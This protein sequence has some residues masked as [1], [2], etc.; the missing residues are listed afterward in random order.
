MTLVETRE[1]TAGQLHAGGRNS[2]ATGARRRNWKIVRLLVLVDVL[3]VLLAIVVSSAITDPGGASNPGWVALT[4]PLVLVTFSF[5]RLYERD[6][7]QISVST[8]DELRD[9]F[10]AL[11]LVCFHRACVRARS[12]RERHHPRPLH[13]GRG[14]LRCGAGAD[15]RDRAVLR[16]LVLPRTTFPAGNAR[17]RS[18]QG[19]PGDREEDPQAPALQRQ[20]GRVPGRRSVGTRPGAGRHPGARR[21]A[22]PRGDDRAPPDLEGGARLLALT[23][24]GSAERR[25]SRRPPGRAGFDRPSVLRAD[26]SERR[27]RR[28]RG[29][30]PARASGSGAFA[31]RPFHQA[32]V[33]S[34]RH[35]APPRPPLAVARHHRPGDQAGLE[36]TGVLPAGSDRQWRPHVPDLQV[37]DDGVRRRVPTSRPA[38]RRTSRLARS[39]RS[40]TTRA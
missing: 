28:C 6:R 24:R 5:Y 18:G 36:R 40:G 39:S 26:R 14:V 34:R 9:V 31:L 30:R 10:N 23:A 3:A 19:R 33:R 1:S 17:G 25:S 4:L 27:H 12:R 13:H 21:R 11:A 35:A 7:R 15:P 20:G 38:R 37:Q 2:S 22:R 32:D 16:L 8:L 29:N